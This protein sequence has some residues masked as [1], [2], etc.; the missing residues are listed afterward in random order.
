MI[1]VSSDDGR[2]VDVGSESIWFSIYSTVTVRLQSINKEI[3]HAIHFMET[4][5]CKATDAFETARQFNLIRDA[6]AQIKPENA[7]FNKDDL[8]LKAPWSNNLS[9]VITSCG[10]LYTTAD[11]KDLLFEV[12]SILTYA[13]YMN[14]DVKTNG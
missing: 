13:H 12:V 11:G 14:V 1:I 3:R 5:N 8:L 9:G 2:Y 7:V 6:F 10:N 4:G